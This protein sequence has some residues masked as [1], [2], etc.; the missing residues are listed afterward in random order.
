M[1]EHNVNFYPTKHMKYPQ[2]TC[3][4]NTGTIAVVAIIT[5]PVASTV[6]THSNMQHHR[7]M[8]T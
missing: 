4:H 6:A 3:T 8:T 2:H 5:A 7:G 1:Y